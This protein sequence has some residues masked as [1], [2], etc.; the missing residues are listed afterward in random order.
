[1]VQET[2]RLYRKREPPRP[3]LPGGAFDNTM[4]I[5]GFRSRALDRET[6]KA[7]VAPDHRGVTITYLVTTVLTVAFARFV[8][9]REQAAVQV[10][11][12]PATPRDETRR[13][14]RALARKV[15]ASRPKQTIDSPGGGQ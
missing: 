5:V 1:M 15:A 4:M 9:F 3:V 13:Y 8:V 11:P 14:R 7:L 10:E 6:A 12:R 2:I